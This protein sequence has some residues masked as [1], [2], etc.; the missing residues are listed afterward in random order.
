MLTPSRS[1]GSSHTATRSV[2]A[3]S[4]PYASRCKDRERQTDR[5]T[6]R[7]RHWPRQKH[8]H[9]SVRACLVGARTRAGGP[10]AR[11]PSRGRSP[12]Q[13][14]GCLESAQFAAQTASY[15]GLVKEWGAA[16]APSTSVTLKRGRETER[17]R[18]GCR[19]ARRHTLVGGDGDGEAG[20][21]LLTQAET[22]AHRRQQRRE[23]QGWVHV[24]CHRRAR[25]VRRCKVQ[26]APRRPQHQTLLRERS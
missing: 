7:H 17:E 24:N 14:R 25:I 4:L 2:A 15:P 3:A 1:R 21:I 11:A 13:P 23:R 19:G 5:Q 20:A 26:G 9:S 6:D 22:A 18:G 8:A 12:G 10:H 16:P